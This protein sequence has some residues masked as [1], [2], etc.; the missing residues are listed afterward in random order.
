MKKL[1]RD[2][3]SSIDDFEDL[4][5]FADE[6]FDTE[7]VDL[8]EFTSEESSPLTRLK[9]IILSLDWE[10]N[11]EILQE[12]ADELKNLQTMWPDDKVAETYLQGLEKIGNYIRIK[13]AYAHPNSIKL[14]LTFFYNF[15]KIISSEQITGEQITQ[16]LKGDV[17]KFR[18][19]Q[20]QIK[21]SETPSATEPPPQIEPSVPTG[22]LP[23]EEGDLTKQLIA[24]ILSLDWEVTDESL[25]Q[26]SQ[27]VTDLHQSV[28]ENKSAMVLIQG[29]QALGDY[30]ADER[31]DAH[32][33]SFVL[34]H[35]F[36]E[37]LKTILHRQDPPLSQERVEEIL[38][39]QVNRLNNLKMAIT[40]PQAGT[41]VD[42]Q[43]IS[44]VVEEVSDITAKEAEQPIPAVESPI[45]GLT[46][47][48]VENSETVPSQVTDASTLEL[49]AE[50]STF[51]GMDA[52]PAMESAD[53]QYPDEILPPDAIHPVDDELAD[54]FIESHLSSKRGLTPALSDVDDTSAPTEEDTFELPGQSALAAELDLLFS[55]TEEASAIASAEK[56][57]DDRLSFDTADN[58]PIAALSDI[59]AKDAFTSSGPTSDSDDIINDE[60]AV[61]PALPETE[62]QGIFEIQDEL[63][64]FFT[65]TAE[66][67]AS[68]SADEEDD[69]APALAGAEEERGFSEEAEIAALESSPLKGIEEKLD[70]FFGDDSEMAADQPDSYESAPAATFDETLAADFTALDQAG[71][72]HAAA[73][74]PELAAGPVQKQQGEQEEDNELERALDNFFSESEETL[75]TPVDD[76]AVDELT[77]TLEATIDNQTGSPPSADQV[78]VQLATLGA[79]LPAV[80]RTPS[81]QNVAEALARITTLRQA[82]LAQNQ[83]PLLQML[84]TVLTFLL[85]LPITD[86]KATEKLVNYFYEQLLAG[87]DHTD[88]LSV[89]VSRFTTWLLQA[90]SV[91][92][93]VPTADDQESD[94]KFT[95]TAKELY[96]E[97]AGLRSHIRDEFAQL[98]HEML[99]HK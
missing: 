70:F 57:T 21:Q 99:H 59:D 16:L 53:V 81:Q 76:A 9:S 14:L 19:L 77:K 72:V 33:E 50:I 29:L 95:Y 32:P 63:D 49:E 44:A 18:I 88:N 92:P 6:S 66:E 61:H 17:R 67:P 87:S 47:T 23:P 41:P 89:A 35:S 74:T 64:R 24:A 4:T 80:V 1:Q 20:Y 96:F 78:E 25:R 10:I 82:E 97:L 7:D 90:G 73:D 94:P 55:D 15:E 40:T 52:M 36:S 79:L 38:I 11:D 31:I 75:A 91:L 86:G 48:T 46:E 12:L 43:R 3:V 85:R 65:E 26:F 13:G 56:S 62:D 34:L 28:S 58:G 84:E 71:E 5:L 54:D 98:R 30:I 51:F 68:F 27:A 93:T 45:T 42:E 60:A 37:N 22:T 39:D 69:V 8:F 83:Q 2:Q